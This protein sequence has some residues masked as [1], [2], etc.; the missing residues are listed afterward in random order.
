MKNKSKR[1]KIVILNDDDY[2]PKYNEI[3]VFSFWKEKNY[4]SFNMIN[5]ILAKKLGD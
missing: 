5:F 1:K 2:Y 3:S 4:K